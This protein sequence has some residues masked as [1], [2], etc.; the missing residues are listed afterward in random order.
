MEFRAF[1]IRH[2]APS[3]ALYHSCTLQQ[4]EQDLSPLRLS[5]HQPGL[6]VEMLGMG[7]G[8]ALQNMRFEN[9]EYNCLSPYG[10]HF[11]TICLI[12]FNP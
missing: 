2:E 12:A 6:V 4:L 3:S 7:S 8:P 9:V 11:G 1:L 5:K 10:S